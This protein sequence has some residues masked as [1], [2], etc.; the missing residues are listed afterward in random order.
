MKYVYMIDYENEYG[1]DQIECVSAKDLLQTLKC[2][3]KSQEDGKVHYLKKV[4]KEDR[5]LEEDISDPLLNK[6]KKILGYTP[7]RNN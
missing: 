6:C 3:F 4:M 7:D 5:W 2:T 1:A